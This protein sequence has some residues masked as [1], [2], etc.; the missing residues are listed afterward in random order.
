MG[1]AWRAV[2]YFEQN[3]KGRDFVVGDIHGAYDLVLLA[4]REA[5]FDPSRDRLFSVG[6][7]VNRGEGSYRVRKFLDQPWVHACRGN[8]EDMLIKAYADGEPSQGTLEW[9]ARQIGMHWWFGVGR[10]ERNAILD[11]I[12]KLPLAMQLETNRG[13]VGFLHA[14]VRSGMSWPDVLT[15]LE[16]GDDQVTKTALWG[17]DRLDNDDASGVSGIGRLFVGHT[18]Q[19]GGVRRLGNVFGMDTG[20]V[21]AS[22]KPEKDAR[23]SMFNVVADT[24]LL[25]ERRERRLI[26]VRDNQSFDLPAFN[27][28]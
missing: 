1:E 27:D 9:L 24:D 16:N 4:M 12:R 21:F 2:R 7:L 13:T 18:P 11:A 8:H 22:L 17:R 23:L 3:N 6:D 10:A 28:L 19:W 20:A 15:R 26:D 14:D 5:R 25:A